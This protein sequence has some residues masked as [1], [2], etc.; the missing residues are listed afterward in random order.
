MHKDFGGLHV[1]LPKTI[2]HLVNYKSF[3][4]GPFLILIYK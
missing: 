1:H 2:L 3:I 4:A